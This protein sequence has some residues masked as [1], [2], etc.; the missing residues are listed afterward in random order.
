M[1][2]HSGSGNGKSAHVSNLGRLLTNAIATSPE[3]FAN[4]I[5]GQAYSINF[6]ATPTGPGDCFFYLK[7]TGENDMIIE[8][9]GL[10]L[11]ANEYIDIVLGDSGTPAGGGAI[12]PVNLNSGSGNAL[13]ATVQDGNDIT[14]LSGG[15]TAYRFYNASSNGTQY[16]NFEMDI[17]LTKNSVFTM[18]VQ[19]GTTALAGYLDVM[20]DM[21]EI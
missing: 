12:T 4:H 11:A 2:I 16:T 6:N 8:G 5:H 10:K 7:N 3:H 21:G 1:I 15:S 20:V 17:I 14:G 18:Y 13:D 19:T 9:F